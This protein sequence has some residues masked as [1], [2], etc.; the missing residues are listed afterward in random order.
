MTLKLS[1]F[2]NFKLLFQA[3]SLD[4]SYLLYI[5]TENFCDKGE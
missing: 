5:K 3:A 2:T 4:F 1:H